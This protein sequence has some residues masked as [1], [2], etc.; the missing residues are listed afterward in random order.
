LSSE[1]RDSFI[2][3]EIALACIF[4]LVVMKTRGGMAELLENAYYKIFAEKQMQLSLS[5]SVPPTWIEKNP[6]AIKFDDVKIKIGSVKILNGIEFTTPTTGILCIVGPNGAGKT[7]LLNS[8]TGGLPVSSGAILLNEGKVENR[9]PYKALISGIGRK[10]QVPSI[11]FSMTTFENLCLATLA[12]RAKLTDY[13]KPSTLTWRSKE[14]N[15]IL[16]TPALPLAENMIQPASALAQGHRQFLEFAMTVAAEPRILLL[17]EP[18]AGLS[19]DETKLMTKLVKDFQAKN[20][21]L[22]ILIEHD[23]SIV[24]S[25]ANQVLVLHQ[26][27]VLAYGNYQEISTNKRV[28]EVYSGGTK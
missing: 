9:P 22:V 23:M 4:I 17:D 15:N 24:K 18:C 11:F 25:L 3:W 1:L 27:C 26:G 28:I 5:T 8:I 21:G 2:Y 20:G 10:L 14:L 7:S 13:F 6:S 19:P 16:S 12:G